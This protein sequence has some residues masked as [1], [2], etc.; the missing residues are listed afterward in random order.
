MLGLL[1]SVAYSIHAL[2]LP[3]S[4]LRYCEDGLSL[5]RPLAPIDLQPLL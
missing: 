1:D 5:D 2:K 4:P 3:S